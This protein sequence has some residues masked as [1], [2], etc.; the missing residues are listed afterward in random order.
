MAL[1]VSKTTQKSTIQRACDFISTNTPKRIK[2]Q[3]TTV[4]ALSALAILTLVLE[5][6]HK[7][8]TKSIFGAHQE[9][10][11]MEQKPNPET[12][13]AKETSENLPIKEIKSRLK[14][15]NEN[16]H[17]IL[18]ETDLEDVKKVI[19]NLKKVILAEKPEHRESLKKEF[20]DL[21]YTYG[22]LCLKEGSEDN[23]LEAKVYLKKAIALAENLNNFHKL[24]EAIVLLAEGAIAQNNKA[25]NSTEFSKIEAS[26]K[27]LREIISLRERILWITP[28]EYFVGGK[29]FLA[30][31]QYLYAFT[32]YQQHSK[33][34]LVEAHSFLLKAK[35]LN[36]SKADDLLEKI[37]R[38]SN[39]QKL[40]APSISDSEGEQLVQS[41]CNSLEKVLRKNSSSEMQS[42][43]EKLKEAILTKDLKNK[44]ELKYAYA[45]IC[46]Q[47]G[48]KENIKDAI[49][50]LQHPVNTAHQKSV[51]LLVKIMLEKE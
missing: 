28:K 24:E 45:S 40:A 18:N 16:A 10:P 12:S 34:S 42:L 13:K 44:K 46:Y 43:K 30:E 50:N 51:D 25:L 26:K 38:I 11:K 14:S 8:I 29:E 21:Y 27:N 2:E 7:S 15:L 9:D 3:K 33:E 17:F 35:K 48:G 39:N 23:L 4:I 6:K 1:E 32:C 31:L 5:V 20:M 41:L 49:K 36:L 19:K 37:S 22:S 47:Q